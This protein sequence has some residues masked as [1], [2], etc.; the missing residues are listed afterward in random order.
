MHYTASVDLAFI[1]VERAG[2]LA[3]GQRRLVQVCACLT[4]TGYEHR[5][6]PCSH[7]ITNARCLLTK[8]IATSRSH[9]QLSST[10]IF[11][12]NAA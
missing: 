10:A 11:I 7:H 3:L 12:Q 6:I 4:N 8:Q 9:T 2:L 1:S 5:H